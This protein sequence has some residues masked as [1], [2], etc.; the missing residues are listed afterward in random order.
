V[1]PCKFY[2]KD[3]VGEEKNATVHVMQVGEQAGKDIEVG[4]A[5]INLSAYMG[6]EWTCDSVKIP[7]ILK[8]QKMF[9]KISVGFRCRSELVDQVFKEIYDTVLKRREFER[10]TEEDRNEKV[11]AAKYEQAVMQ[12][13]INYVQK[14]RGLKE[15]AINNP[16]C[17]AE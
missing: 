2:L 15:Q 10:L 5:K 7:V 13:N 1:R 17:R 4:S 3:G 6:E 11:K 14:N 9:A 8:Y 16:D 12:E